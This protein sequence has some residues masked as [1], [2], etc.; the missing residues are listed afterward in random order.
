MAE[1]NL[2]PFTPADAEKAVL[3]IILARRMRASVLAPELFSEPAWDLLLILFLARLRR[4]RMTMR[5]LARGTGI[6]ETM[7]GRW[8]DVLDGQGLI[9]RRPAAQS[10]ERRGFVELS[11]DGWRA[12]QRWLEEWIESRSEAGSDKRVLDLLWRIQQDND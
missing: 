5:Q 9:R 11:P 3:Q 2:Y 6:S 4:Q 8:L 12:M 7:A 10:R 1:H